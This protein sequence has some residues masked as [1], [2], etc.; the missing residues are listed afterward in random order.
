[1]IREMEV[2]EED[3]LGNTINVITKLEVEAVAT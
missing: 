3:C 2:D 1:L